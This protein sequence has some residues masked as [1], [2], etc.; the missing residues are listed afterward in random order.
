MFVHGSVMVSSEPAGVWA[1]LVNWTE[2][3]RWI[4]LTRMAVIGDKLTGLGVRVRAQ[5]G[6]WIGSVLFG[7]TDNL[8]VTGWNPPYELEISHVGP[9]FTGV[10]VFTLQPRGVRSFLTIRERINVP[11][12]TG[13]A[14][15]IAQPML[16]GLLNQS[17]HRFA[18]LVGERVPAATKA[19]DPAAIRAAMA[20]SPERIITEIKHRRARRSRRLEQP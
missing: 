20:R 9:A 13:T 11:A 1:E 18:H 8:T 3:H 7:L 19:I 17:M 10:G 12:G 2:Q 15:A 6:L 16:Q 14:A 5:H 4:P